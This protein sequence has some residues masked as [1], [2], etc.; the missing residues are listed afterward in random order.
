MAF[1]VGIV[2][3]T[4]ALGA[5]SV[6]LEAP[7]AEIV[8]TSGTPNNF[9]MNQAANNVNPTGTQLSLPPGFTN[10]WSDANATWFVRPDTRAVLPIAGN[11][12]NT[13]RNANTQ[14]GT[15]PTQPIAA[16]N[17]GVYRLPTGTWVTNDARGNRVNVK[18]DQRAV[19]A[20][21]LSLY[22]I[23]NTNSTGYQTARAN[24]TGSDAEKQTKANSLLRPL[25]GSVII[26]NSAEQYKNIRYVLGKLGVTS[27][28][29]DAHQ[30]HFHVTMATP[31]AAAIVTPPNNLLAEGTE[32][33]LTMMDQNINYADIVA[34]ANATTPPAIVETV[35]PSWLDGRPE[36]RKDIEKWIKNLEGLRSVVPYTYTEKGPLGI[37]SLTYENQLDYLASYQSSRRLETYAQEISPKVS[38]TILDVEAKKAGAWGPECKISKIIMRPRGKLSWSKSTGEWIDSLSYTPPGNGKRATTDSVRFILENGEGKKVDVMIKINIGAYE[39][40]RGSLSPDTKFA[41]NSWPNEQQDLLDQSDAALDFSPSAYSKPFAWSTVLNAAV[42]SVSAITN[43]PGTAV[44]ETTGT[45]TTATITLDTNAAGH[46]WFIDSTRA[47]NDEYLPTSD[48]N[49]WIAKAGSAAE[50]KMDMLSVLLHEYGHALGFEHSANTADFMSAS[51]VA[52]E[53]NQ[54]IKGVSDDF[55][56]E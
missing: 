41:S 20:Q 24:F 12:N 18:N 19:T 51:L 52:G 43:L 37:P 25:F 16:A 22:S 39:S 8:T 23:T 38:C 48:A 46:G 50:G 35:K 54:R 33:S 9:S 6:P 32:E 3:R 21:I 36:H 10:G 30:H 28:T 5:N 55:F 13:I 56:Q 42:S 34:L 11:L 26:G 7:I 14:E 47:D 27:L 4:G 17:P 45:G 40:D 49:V 15:D 53:K 1:D 2:P 29:A 44:G 31:E